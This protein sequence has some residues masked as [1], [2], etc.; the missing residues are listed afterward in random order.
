MQLRL[1][2]PEC[3]ALLT[4]IYIASGCGR[5]R[6][7]ELIAKHQSPDKRSLCSVV[8]D[9]GIPAVRGIVCLHRENQPPIDGEVIAVF[10]QLSQDPKC[11]WISNNEI[12]I[13]FD[14]A[15]VF[16]G[17]PTSEYFVNYQSRWI[18]IRLL[19]MNGTQWNDQEVAQFTSKDGRLVHPP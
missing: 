7:F 3:F 19:K 4:A 10:Y 15:N 1:K 8:N 16:S 9:S 6:S 5:E 14:G 2:C 18:K 12:S 11:N 17:P 13:S